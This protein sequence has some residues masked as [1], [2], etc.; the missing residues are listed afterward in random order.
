VKKKKNKNLEKRDKPSNLLNKQMSSD[1]FMFHG[2]KL[3]NQKF[4]KAKS[5]MGNAG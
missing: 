2:E 4:E 5:A 3:L 1:T